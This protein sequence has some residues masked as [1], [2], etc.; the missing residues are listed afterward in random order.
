MGPLSVE[1]QC[2][3]ELA[4][5]VD[6]GLRWSG[7]SY[8]QSGWSSLQKQQCNALGVKSEAVNHRYLYTMAFAVAIR[9]RSDDATGRVH[10]AVR[11][12][13]R[14]GAHRLLP[15]TRLLHSPS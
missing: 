2:T 12:E 8:Q 14:Q 9:L 1:S 4:R 10:R 6:N 5:F 7:S 3:P 13:V 15:M 11:W